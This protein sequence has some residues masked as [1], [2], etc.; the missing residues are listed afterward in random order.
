MRGILK[1]LGK[2]IRQNFVMSRALLAPFITAFMIKFLLAGVDS[3]A[4][5]AIYITI[6]ILIGVFFSLDL[7]LQ[8]N[9][10]VFPDISKDIEEIKTKLNQMSIR[11]GFLK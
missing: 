8:N 7:F 3:A 9:K 11:D 10:P 2:I 4:E 6:A 5:A 1:R